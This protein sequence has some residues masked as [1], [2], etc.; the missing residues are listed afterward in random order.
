MF[1]TDAFVRL[2][3]T[4]VARAIGATLLISV[5]GPPCRA[6]ANS[7]ASAQDKAISAAIAQPHRKPSFLWDYTSV[8]FVTNR[9]INENAADTQVADS[10]HEFDD[11][12]TNE[13]N[14]EIS[15]GQACVAYP[16]GRKI[17]EQ[18][19]G[20]GAE[21]HYAGGE[22]VE[23]PARYFVTKGV[24]PIGSTQDFELAIHNGGDAS[25]AYNCPAAG[26]GSIDTPVIYIHGYATPFTAAITRGS[27]LKLDLDRKT[28]IVVSWPSDQPGLTGYSQSENEE[29]RALSLVPLVADLLQKSIGKPSSVIAHSMGAR[30][31]TDGLR[32]MQS[33]NDP[34]AAKTFTAI[35]AAPDIDNDNFNN[36]LSFFLNMNHYTTVYCAEDWALKSSGIVHWD[37]RLGYCKSDEPRL[38]APEEI[39]RVTGKFKDTWRHSYFLSAPEMI[40]DMKAALSKGEGNHY[41]QGTKEIPARVLELQ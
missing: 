4:L 24:L 37:K 20:G 9:K 6:D 29:Q 17:A 30:L 2:R 39:V 18:D 34:T 28:M 38:G 27:Q 21:Q 13:F 36:Q 35:L 15:L 16:H 19:Y 33:N 41:T 40:Y 11:Y 32:L 12:Y 7:G 3:G 22:A 5:C 1:R 10:Q 26:L 8:F 14:F 31:Y 25:F 23:S